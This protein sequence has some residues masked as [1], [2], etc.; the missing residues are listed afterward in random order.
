MVGSELA[1][2]DTEFSALDPVGRDESMLRGQQR[3]N[4]VSL[5]IL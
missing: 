1:S 4:E 3:E 2:L 5:L